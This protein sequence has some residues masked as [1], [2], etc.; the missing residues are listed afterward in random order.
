[1]TRIISP[2]VVGKRGPREGSG[3][4]RAE[5]EDAN[6][7]MG[8]AMRLGIPV[9]KRRDTKYGENVESLKVY[10]EEARK[11]GIKIGKP[12]IEAKRKKGRANRGLT[13]AGK[14]IRGLR[15]NR[16]LKK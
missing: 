1:M 15:K 5:L 10:V 9:D 6:I 7:S 11:A 8:E 16:G 4:S 14:K 3:F 13:S 12:S 2:I